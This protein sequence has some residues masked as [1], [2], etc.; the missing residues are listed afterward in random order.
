MRDRYIETIEVPAK[1]VREHPKNWRVH[2][3]EQRKALE[4][5]LGRVGKLTALQGTRLPDGTI[6][7]FDGHLRRDILGGDLVRVDLYDLS[8]EEVEL[9][10]ATFDPISAMAEADLGRLSGLLESTEDIP[11]QI[12]KELVSLLENEEKKRE[13]EGEKK[14]QYTEKIEAPIYEP[15][16]EKPQIQELF[17]LGRADTLLQ[18]IEKTQGISEDERGFLRLAAHRHIVFDFHKIAD[19]YAHSGPVMQRLMEHSALVII[20]YEKAIELGYVRVSEELLNQWKK[21]NS[22]E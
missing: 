7:I 17:S 19:Y 2:P 21:E 1:Q 5:I 22:D 8:P 12:A 10:L 15:K 18:E 6:E 11:E 3:P 20:D 4:Q 14:K 9:V 13:E 16:G